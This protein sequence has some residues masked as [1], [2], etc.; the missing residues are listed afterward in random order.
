MKIY[1][2]G[3]KWIIIA[4]GDCLSGDARPKK[5]ELGVGKAYISPGKVVEVKD[6]V[7]KNLIKKYPLVLMEFG[8]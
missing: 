1:N 4:V 3:I 2:R 7:G 5:D 8:K 6:E